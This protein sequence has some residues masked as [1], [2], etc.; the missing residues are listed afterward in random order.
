MLWITRQSNAPGVQAP[1]LSSMAWC[2]SKSL[3]DMIKHKFNLLPKCTCSF[4]QLWGIRLVRYLQFTSQ[5][6]WQLHAPHKNGM[7]F[8]TDCPKM[9]STA[10]FDIHFW[11]LLNAYGIRLS[12]RTRFQLFQPHHMIRNLHTFSQH[13]QSSRAKQNMCWT[14]LNTVYTVCMYINI[15][16]TS[17]KIKNRSYHTISKFYHP[18]SIF[19]RI[20]NASAGCSVLLLLVQTQLLKFTWASKSK[21]NT[22]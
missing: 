9:V 18:L 20:R 8:C 1:K 16:Y 2:S 3:D 15:L 4:G 22:H 17:E 6:R 21:N 14:L 11:N 19:S 13:S 12:I 7:V 10:S 5:P